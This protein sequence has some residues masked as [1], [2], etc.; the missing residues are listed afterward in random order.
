MLVGLEVGFAV[1]ITEV[2]SN[3]NLSSNDK[4]HVLW[5]YLLRTLFSWSN[6]ICEPGMLFSQ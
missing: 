2:S 6:I 1:P 3:L 5:I 4:R